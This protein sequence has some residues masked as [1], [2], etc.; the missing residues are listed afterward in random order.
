MKG[1]WP[2]CRRNPE[3]TDTARFIT[4][5]AVRHGEA[6]HNIRE[7]EAK[8]KAEA[9]LRESDREGT[10]PQEVHAAQEAARQ[11]ALTDPCLRDAPLSDAGKQGALSARDTIASLV[12]GGLPQ[13]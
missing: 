12:Q 11:E 10:S 5:Y 3:R 4:L 13:R 7:K 8:H 1:C 6:F 2:C 9:K